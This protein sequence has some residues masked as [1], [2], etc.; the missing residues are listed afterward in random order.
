MI[1]SYIRGYDFFN[2]G[3]NRTNYLEEFEDCFRKKLED[4]DLISCLHINIDI[5]SILE[6]R[7][8]LNR[9]KTLTNRTK[10]YVND[11]LNYE[12]KLIDFGCSKYFVNKKKHRKLSGIIGSTLYCSPEVVDN[13]YDSVRPT[14]SAWMS[15]PSS[16]TTN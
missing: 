2:I 10:N 8:E 13:L 16:S 3:Y 4:C 6:L 9:S 7:T 5:N 15:A 12:I 1:T 14:A 11:M